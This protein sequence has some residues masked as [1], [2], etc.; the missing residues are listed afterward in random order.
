MS[1]PDQFNFNSKRLD[2]LLYFA[3]IYMTP[4]HFTYVTV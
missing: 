3:Y 4:Y 1:W 2:Q